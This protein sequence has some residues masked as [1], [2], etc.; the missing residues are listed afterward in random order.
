MR[1]I[2]SI[3]VAWC[4]SLLAVGCGSSG[5]ASEPPPP[6]DTASPVG[7]LS[8]AEKGQL[9]D[10]GTR[11]LLG[12]YGV[13]IHC[14]DNTVTT[15]PDQAVCI[16]QFPSTCTYT[17]GEYENCIEIAAPSPCDLISAPAC[18]ALFIPSCEVQ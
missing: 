12:G 1:P 16:T 8:D 15:A 2:G 6:I 3:P 14:G 13:V 9:C 18:Q 5:K 17:V 10:W 7:P 4:L 11:E